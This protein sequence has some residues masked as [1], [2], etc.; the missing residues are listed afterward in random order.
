M[1]PCTAHDHAGR[2]GDDLNG[3]PHLPDQEMK[4]TPEPRFLKSYQ[5]KA[6]MGRAHVESA[7]VAFR[8]PPTEAGL[9]LKK[10]GRYD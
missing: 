10:G 4:N 7:S 1:S 9:P 8:W 6:A 2:S 5:E 3:T